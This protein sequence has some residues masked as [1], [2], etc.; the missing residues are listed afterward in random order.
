M[1]P[2]HANLLT[3]F[4]SI[5]PHGNGYK[6]QTQYI[7]LAV[8]ALQNLRRSPEMATLWHGVRDLQPNQKS[9]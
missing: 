2:N 6:G 1:G 4:Q 8:H 5:A 3:T 9:G 7:C